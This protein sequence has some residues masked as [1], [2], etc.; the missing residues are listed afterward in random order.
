MIIDRELQVALVTREM[1]NVCR[2]FASPSHN[3]IFFYFSAINNTTTESVLPPPPTTRGG[4]QLNQAV[5][6][7]YASKT[8]RSSR[9]GEASIRR[10]FP[11][12]K[13]E[14]RLSAAS[15]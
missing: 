5:D 10:Y 1:G 3:K 6:S 15:P 12:T 7:K 9:E 11:T 14:A 8:A 2:A 4:G 13:K